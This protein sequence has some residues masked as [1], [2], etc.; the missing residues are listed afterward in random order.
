MLPMLV[1]GVYAASVPDLLS[2]GDTANESNN[3]KIGREGGKEKKEM[4]SIQYHTSSSKY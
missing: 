2:M 1:R 3:G 4:E